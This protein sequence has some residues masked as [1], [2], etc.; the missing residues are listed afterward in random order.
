MTEVTRI[1]WQVVLFTSW[2]V[3]RG[4]ACVCALP[5]YLKETL[6]MLSRYS[7]I[8][9][10]RCDHFGVVMMELKWG[11]TIGHH[12]GVCTSHA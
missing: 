8:A 2:R 1:A 7:N 5:F 11:Y 3:S 9:Q 4:T 12:M 10:W 6:A